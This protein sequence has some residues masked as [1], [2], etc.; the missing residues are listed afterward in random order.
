M[1][2]MES[3]VA[4]LLA[5]ACPAS[6]PCS[7][8]S[9]ASSSTI[10]CNNKGLRTLPHFK[11]SGLHSDT[12][13]IDMGSNS[14]ATI[15]SNAFR[16]TSRI[17]A[18]KIVID[19]S[20]NQL[21]HINDD[22]FSGLENTYRID[23]DMRRNNLSSIPIAVTKLK[24]LEQLNIEYNPIA[25]F[26][27]SVMYTLGYSL[28]ELYMDLNL[29]RVWPSEIRFLEHLRILEIINIPFARLG[30]TIFHGLE[31]T[32]TSL[33]IQQSNLLEQIPP[34]ICNLKTLHYFNI[35]N[36][37]NLNSNFFSV[38]H[39]CQG[40]HSTITSIS[41]NRNN[42]SS[43]PDIRSIPSLTFLDLSDNNLEI[44]E[45]EKIPVNTNLSRI[46]IEKNKFKR[47]PGELNN[48]QHLYE[49]DMGYNEV[50]SV[51][52]Y[53]LFALTNLLS[54]YLD[55]NPI[56]YISANAFQNNNK[57]TFLYL[58]NTK[59]TTMPAAV[60]NLPKHLSLHM[61][62]LNIECTCDLSYLR[63][64]DVSYVNLQF[65]SQSDCTFSHETIKHYIMTGLPQCS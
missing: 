59:L 57:L 46:F 62:T 29:F 5:D 60:L 65:D 33:T 18:T 36:C 39:Y 63:H 23:L 28:K 43:F 41:I 10:D 40:D 30:T 61:P 12:L 37:P 52:D 49:I 4:F 6:L 20:S 13:T 7:C 44:I 50:L 55:N 22:A 42:I 26:Q 53:D 51:E 21:V 14:M 19:L 25:S 45:E 31:H 34:A 2:M 17:N 3:T 9:H 64:W 35:A 24:G 47:I 27:S 56:R 38:F 16:N 48:M 58:S 32:L 1:R 54:L 15:P 8:S 11:H